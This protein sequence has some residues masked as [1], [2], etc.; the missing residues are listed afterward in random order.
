MVE[1]TRAKI[2]GG[3]GIDRRQGHDVTVDGLT[4]QLKEAQ[5]KAIAE[6]KG[7]SAAVSATSRNNKI[8]TRFAELTVRPVMRAHGVKARAARLRQGFRKGVQ[9]VKSSPNPR[10]PHGVKGAT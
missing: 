10:N 5:E 3:K 6:P 4:D 8:V 1:G 2:A 9:R 7:A